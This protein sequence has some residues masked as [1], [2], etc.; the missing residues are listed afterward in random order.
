MSSSSKSSSTGSC[1]GEST[2]RASSS[3][4]GE[5]T[6]NRV[7]KTRCRFEELARRRGERGDDAGSSCEE[8]RGE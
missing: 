5:T 1:S 8:D 6:S 4:V 7:S 2:W 3:T